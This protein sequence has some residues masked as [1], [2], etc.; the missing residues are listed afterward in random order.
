[1]KKKAVAKTT[2]LRKPITEKDKEEIEQWYK[3]AKDM[4]IE[5]LPEFMRHLTEDYDHD[6][7]T[8]CKAVTAGA[9]AAANAIDHSSQGGITGFQAGAIMWEFMSEWNHVGF[10]ARLIRYE[11]ALFPQY[12][13]Q[14]K[15]ISEETWDWLQKEAKEHL[16]SRESACKEVKAHWKS[17]VDGK[18]PFGLL[19]EKERK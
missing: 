18:V 1:M 7:G 17:I 4:T 6:Y 5:K 2:V 11:E 12:E 9:C 3:D 13:H 14:F 10:P 15:S 16:K 19:V 8:I